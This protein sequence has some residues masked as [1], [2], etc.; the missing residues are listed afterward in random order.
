VPT[1]TSYFL[2]MFLQRSPA[3]L[4]VLIGIIFAL[5]R[6]NR[7]PKVSLLTLLALLLYIAKFVVFTGLYYSVPELARHASYDLGTVLFGVLDV[8]ND[9]AA[10]VVIVLLVVAAFI[11]REPVAAIN[12]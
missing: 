2:T 8:L 3:F 5:V 10:A 6:W 7:H 11:K 4:V 9:V 1:I 12:N